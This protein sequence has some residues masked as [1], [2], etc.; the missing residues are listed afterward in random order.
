MYVC[1]CNPVTDTQVRQA[2]SQGCQSLSALQSALGVGAGC[3]RCT[4]SASEILAKE[5]SRNVE[6]R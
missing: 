6:G 3:G 2:I 5:Q 1:I 4:E